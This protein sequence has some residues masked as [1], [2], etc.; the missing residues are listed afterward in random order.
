MYSALLFGLVPT[1][2]SAPQFNLY[3]SNIFVLA[4]GFCFFI[5]GVGLVW[6]TVR[7]RKAWGRWV[8]LVAIAMSAQGLLVIPQLFFSIFSVSGS[9]DWSPVRLLDPAV[10]RLAPIVAQSVLQVIA[11]FFLF[12]PSANAWFDKGSAATAPVIPGVPVD[13]KIWKSTI[14]KMN[15]GFLIAYGFLIFGLDLAIVVS[16]PSLLSF[17]QMMLAVFAV[18]VVFFLLETFV[19]SKKFSASLSSAD[20]SIVAVIVIGT[21]SFC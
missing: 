6:L 19:Y 16:N 14:P 15:L 13:S 5:L 7:R 3:G 17:W 21:C 1:A 20:G 4:W 18:F 12:S 10:L 9:F 11:L 8:F 2:L